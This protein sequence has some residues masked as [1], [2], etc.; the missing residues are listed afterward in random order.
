MLLTIL[1]QTINSVITDIKHVRDQ[2]FVT[3]MAIHHLLPLSMIVQ[4]GI[5]RLTDHVLREPSTVIAEVDAS[6]QLSRI[7]VQAGIISITA[8]VLQVLL[9]VI[10]MEIAALCSRLIVTFLR[11]SNR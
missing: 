2:E 3:L 11:E 4:H 1:V 10:A 8:H 7:I 9:I 6:Q 5:F